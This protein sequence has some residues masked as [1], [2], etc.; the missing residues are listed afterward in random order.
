MSREVSCARPDL[1]IESLAEL[2]VHGIGCIP[3]VNERG[4]PVGMVTKHELVERI[5]APDRAAELSASELMM[6]F[7]ITLGE[8]ASVAHAAALMA[9]EDI[10]HLP[11][12]DGIGQLIGIV[13]TMDIVRWLAG[14]DG[15]VRTR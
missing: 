7:V 11:I 12:V 3:I 9:S 4:T 2:L 13:S 6:P 5:L 15:F 10:H 8:H 1:D 14:N